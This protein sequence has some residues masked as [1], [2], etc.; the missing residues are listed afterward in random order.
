VIRFRCPV[1][2]KS[3][4]AP[5]DKAG[6]SMICPRCDERSVIPHDPGSSNDGDG[7][8]ARVADPPAGLFVGMS[9]RVR[10]ATMLVAGVGALA[11]LLMLLPL[12]PGVGVRSSPPG[13]GLVATCAFLLLAVI[14]YGQGTGCPCCGK[15]WSRSRLEKEFVDR[16]VFDKDGVPFGRSRYRTTYICG[17][18]GGRWSETEEDEYQAPTPRSRH[19]AR[20]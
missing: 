2:G 18:C 14:L 19:G 6:R 17:E 11:L 16:E 9:P 20:G 13:T 10:W 3:L 5:P 1:C 12:V 8:Q 15:W 4:K 7:L